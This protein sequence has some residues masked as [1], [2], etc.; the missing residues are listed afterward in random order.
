MTRTKTLYLRFDLY[1]LVFEFC[2]LAL[3]TKNQKART[4]TF[5]LRFDLYNLT[6]E[7]SFWL[8]VF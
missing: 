3:R 4:K 6:F 8:L 5:Y 2:Y 1:H 7:F